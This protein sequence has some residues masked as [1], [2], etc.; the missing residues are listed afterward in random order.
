MQA[1]L[2]DTHVLLWWMM[3]HPE[4]PERVR[5][6]IADPEHVIHISAASLWE[7]SVK[8]RQGRLQGVE[9]YLDRWRHWHRVWDF[10]DLPLSADHCLLA[11]SLPIDH[12]DPIDRML[13]IQ[14]RAEHMPLVTDNATIRAVHDA[15]VW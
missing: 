4:L 11:G 5:Q 8:H 7:M 10:R 6:R 9:D 2:L 13:I 1:Y 3:D 14:S 15:C 12:R